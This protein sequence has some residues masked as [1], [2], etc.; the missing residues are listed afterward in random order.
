MLVF[1][2]EVKKPVI[3]TL[4][5]VLSGPSIDRKNI[6]HSISL[7]SEYL[8]VMSKQAV[9]ILREDYDIEDSKII[10]IPHGIHDVDYEQN[11]VVKQRLGY[12]NRLLLTSF[13][14][15]RQGRGKNSY[16]RG[17][18]YVL[19]ALPNIIKQFPNVLY[20]IIGI[21]HPKCLKRNGEKYRDF[22]KK[23]VEELGL[24]NNVKF[25]NKYVSLDEL[26]DYLKATEV[27]VCSSLN[28]HQSS[29][30]TLSYALGSGCAVIST[31]FLSAKE[32]LTKNKGIVLDNFEDSGLISEA[33]IKLLSNQDLRKTMSKNAYSYTRNMT[34]SNVASSYMQLFEKYLV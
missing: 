32:L 23:K 33:V 8:I 12:E 31:P 17:Y 10:V 5:T 14:F 1:L 34:W 2:K 7:Y 13:G 25:I 16:G 6:I 4:H 11:T 9:K 18:E 29:S 19:E 27:Y 26:F 24:E 22:L 30:G 15:L 3:T 21:T 20:L 28:P